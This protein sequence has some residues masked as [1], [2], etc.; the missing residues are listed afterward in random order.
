MIAPSAART[1]VLV[2]DDE[3]GARFGIAK[4]L[5]REGN[6]VELAADGKEG[7]EKICSFHP[8]CV[9]SDINMPNMDGITLLKEVSQVTNPP[10]VILMTAYGSEAMVVQG[11]RAGAYDYISKPFDIEDLRRA[12][13]NAIE[14]H[15]LVE[16]NKRYYEELER[17]LQ[18]LRQ[19]QVERIHAE[20]MAALGRLVAGI[21]HEANS[22]LG[23]LV[24]S[25]D[26]FGRVFSRVK[27]LLQL[28]VADSPERVESLLSAAGSALEVAQEACHRMDSMV[29]T[30]RRFANLDQ[31]PVRRVSVSEC[32]DNALALLKHQ[33]REEIEVIRDYGETPV[34][35]CS[36]MDLS[37]VFMC[38]FLNSIEAISG[39]GKIQVQTRYHD[40]EVLIRIEDTGK[41]I[42]PEN[43]PKI[44][45]P[46]FT[47]KGEGVG[48]GMGLPT[49]QR[50]I[51]NHK[52]KIQ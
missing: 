35:E 51:E 17:T 5:E 49:C 16:E 9:I 29:K 28:E 36:P 20:K 52:G 42:P 50:I 4:V 13:R 24:S 12:V 44:F 21:A 3:E 23:A 34:I 7:L 27:S 48:T 11:L 30:M 26:T 10:P 45:D 2:I 18:E 37:Q 15:R 33:L 32:L 8:Q 6:H 19:S 22:P 46:G 39:A 38:L 14:K 1:R 31:A 40:P 43:M 41:G 47:T 25:V